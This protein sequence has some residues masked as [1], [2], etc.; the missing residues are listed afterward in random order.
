MDAA[1]DRAVLREVGG[2]S[3]GYSEVGELQAARTVDDRV[4]GLQVA[5]HDAAVVDRCG[6]EQDLDGEV[7]RAPGVE[8]RLVADDRLERA[9]GDVLH[10][11]VVSALPLATVVD[12]H[13]VLVRQP[14]RGR[15]LAPEALHQ[16]VIPSEPGMQELDGD[17]AL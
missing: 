12:R 4:V 7:H 6:G 17:L 16:L 9:P 10:R 11:D 5:V 8:R 2:A 15:G 3:A 13:D 1:E 14:R